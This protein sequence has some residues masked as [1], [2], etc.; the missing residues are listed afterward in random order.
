MGIRPHPR[1]HQGIW[2]I[3]AVK[4]LAAFEAGRR[5]WVDR[6]LKLQ[7]TATPATRG[8]GGRGGRGRGRGRSSRTTGSIHR[9]HMAPGPAMIA[10]VSQ[11]V[12][13]EF[14]AG[15]TEIAALG[16]L[17]A[18]WLTAVPVNHPFLHPDITQ[19]NWV[20]SAYE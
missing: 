4:L 9:P 17:P 16:A 18:A 11:V 8:R 3:V 14:W 19:T 10:S 7:N 1:L 20:V 5:N 2:D 12:L 6:V 13:T 15:L